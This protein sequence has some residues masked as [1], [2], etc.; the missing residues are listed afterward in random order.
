MALQKFKAPSLPVPPKGYDQNYMTQ[1]VR[2][3][4]NYFNLLD[5]KT[6]QEIDTVRLVAVP[7]DDTDLKEGSAFRLPTEDLVR[8]VVDGVT[9]ELM[10][11]EAFAEAEASAAE[12]AAVTT[13][14]AY[15]D[16]GLALKVS[17]SGDTM[18]GA[19]TTPAIIATNATLTNLLGATS[20][21][22]GAS[23][24]GALAGSIKAPGQIIQVVRNEYT[25]YTAG[26]AQ[27]WTTA[28]GSATQITPLYATSRLL[29]IIE[30]AMVHGTGSTYAGFSH[31]IIVDGLPISTKPTV[32]HE[33]YVSAG[34][35]TSFGYYDRPVKLGIVSAGSTTTKTIAAQVG[36]YNAGTV[37]VNVPTAGVAMFSSAVTVLEIAG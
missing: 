19:L 7:T 27:V 16:A 32:F 5:S 22:S 18:T 33:Q 10:A 34:N 2:V 21:P 14:N 4:G 26:P 13:A 9:P 29:I 37:E 23:L 25:D 8:I 6:A 20:V 12:A 3:L 15:T 30:T 31:R 24:F 35:T 17:K 1:L 11:T 28:A 36:A